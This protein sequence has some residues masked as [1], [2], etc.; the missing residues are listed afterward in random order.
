MKNE[1]GEEKRDKGTKGQRDRGKSEKPVV[2]SQKKEWVKTQRENKK[3]P[4]TGEVG[5]LNYKL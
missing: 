4:P 1:K 2:R 3:K 5:G